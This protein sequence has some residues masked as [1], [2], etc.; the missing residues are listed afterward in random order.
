MGPVLH[1]NRAILSFIGPAGAPGEVS[2]LSALLS[3]PS[4]LSCSS[5]LGRKVGGGFKVTARKIEI[6]LSPKVTFTQPLSKRNPLNIWNSCGTRC[7]CGMPSVPLVA[8][9]GGPG[10]PRSS[11]LPPNSLLWRVCTGRETA[12]FDTDCELVE[13]S[14]LRL[15][16]GVQLSGRTQVK[17]S[18]WGFWD[19]RARRCSPTCE[20]GASLKPI[21][22]SCRYGRADQ[23]WLR[24]LWGRLRPRQPWSC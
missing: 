4:A 1:Y 17:K 19:P 2:D 15:N 18:Q 3:A 7:I 6:T 21:Y 14:H 10:L 13:N 22:S 16:A 9:R 11:S 12:A 23:I 8:F 5:V 24:E 20:R